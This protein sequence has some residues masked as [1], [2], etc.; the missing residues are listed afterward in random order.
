MMKSPSSILLCA[1]LLAVVTVPSVT[2]AFVPAGLNFKSSRASHLFSTTESSATSSISV[3]SPFDEYS[4]T[5]PNQ[6][7]AYKD[8][9]IGT[10]D[11][12]ETG[13]V[14]TVA[15]KGRMMRDNVQFDEGEKFPFK[16]GQRR[17]MPGW[18]Q[19]VIGMRVGGKRTLRIPP[20]LA[21]GDRWVKNKIPPNSHV[22]FDLELKSIAQNPV[23]ER[24]VML[25]WGPGR[26]VGA[27]LL[28]GIFAIT[29]F[30]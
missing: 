25:N 12:A 13:K 1:L 22:E 8:T 30:I 27:F 17:V 21:Y 19:G 26:I 23:E 18:E 11:V 4:Q 10:G 9:V 14:L 3:G 24:W 29:P 16:V 28:L 20:K 7:L 6:E 5:D 15:Y 2:D